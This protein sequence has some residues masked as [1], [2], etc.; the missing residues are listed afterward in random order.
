MLNR[1]SKTILLVIIIELCLGGG[2]RL[3]TI[4]PVS[5]RMVLFCIAIVLTTLLLLS[6]KS[7]ST[8]YWKILAAF[9]LMNLVGVGLGWLNGSAKILIWEDVKPLL[10]FL[11]LPFFA[12]AIDESSPLNI[13]KIIKVCALLTAS[14]FFLL[15]ILVHSGVFTFLSFYKATEKTVEFF[16]RGEIT[17]FYKGFLFLGIGSIFF[18]FS[19][20]NKKFL[21]V[22][23]LVLAIIFS[24][25]RG[26]LFSLSCTLAAYFIG[27][28]KYYHA[29]SAAIFSLIIVVWG[30]TSTINFSRW[31]DANK[32]DKAYEEASPHLF[33]DRKYSD[34]GRFAQIKEVGERVSL[35]SIFVGHGFG[36]GIPARPIHMEIAYLEIFHK[37]G[38]IGLAF[39][40][41]LAWMLFTAYRDSN[42]SNFA[43]AFFFSSLFVFVE[44]A[45][46]QYFNNPIGMSVLLL[47]L[48]SLY[49]LKNH[50]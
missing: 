3:T 37:Q 26:L 21:F 39:W 49:K 19:E 17:F 25:T 8:R 27:K 33:G 34:E 48:V 35:T 7:I 29:T 11:I 43:N 4:G 6:G 16:Y 2:G 5:L 41:S 9:F 42:R 32:G 40:G 38:L 30:N 18:F 15:L 10:Y 50:L 12:L 36:Q 46:N 14:L 1:I 28:K 44:S 45:T 23:V 20:S 22:T 24:V 47:S 31:I 13:S